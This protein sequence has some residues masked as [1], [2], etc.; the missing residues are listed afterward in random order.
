[1]KRISILTLI[2]VVLLGCTAFANERWSY[3]SDFYVNDKYSGKVFI[4]THTVKDSPGR[5]IA[6]F[7]SV[8]TNEEF[9]REK[10]EMIALSKRMGIINPDTS[11]LKQT[12]YSQIEFDIDNWRYRVLNDDVLI[13]SLP[14]YKE[15]DTIKPDSLMEKEMNVALIYINND[16]FLDTLPPAENPV[17]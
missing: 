3:V 16:N 10:E 12:L 1:M 6:W 4:D 13:K 11:T 14:T 7:K 5:V 17:E 8:S 2:F 9:D 15:W